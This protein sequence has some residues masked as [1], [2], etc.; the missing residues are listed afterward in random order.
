MLSKAHSK[1]ALSSAAATI[2][3]PF[4][5]LLAATAWARKVSLLAVCSQV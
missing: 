4:T 1:K 2:N 5:I 3:K